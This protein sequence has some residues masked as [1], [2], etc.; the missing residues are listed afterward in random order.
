MSDHLPALQNT[1]DDSATMDHLATPVRPPHAHLWPDTAT[2]D[3][4]GQL[5][6]GGLDLLALAR[7][8]GTPLYVYDEATIRAQCR[9][10]HHELT[11]RWPASAVA[12]AGKAYLSLA[13]CRLLADE[14]ME[15]DVVSAGELGLAMAAGFEPARIHLHGNFKPRSELAQALAAGIGRIVVDSL[16][17]LE[18]V[19]ALARERGERVAIWLRVC[20]DVAT[21]TH[22][23]TQT[24][25][26]SS[27]FGLDVASGT[28][29]E[30]AQ[31]AATSEWLDLA[32]LHAHAGS[33]LIDVTP[34]AQTVR[35]LGEL[36]AELRERFGVAIRELSP[37]GGLGVAYA[38]AERA[39]SI[40]EYAKTV[41]GALAS[42]VERK[43][44]LPPQLIVEPGRAIVARAGVALYTVGPRKVVAGGETFLAVDGGMGDNPRPALY[45]AAYHAA[46][47]ERMTAPAEERVRVVGRYCESGDVLVW[48]VALPR[49]RPGEVLAVA[50]GGA[51]QLAMASTYNLVPRPAV[52]FVA[53]GRARL[54]QRRETL[55]DVLARESG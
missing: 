23:H 9:A 38:P 6:V 55:E 19:E 4:S 50:V 47:P 10:L 17:E 33:H 48:D 13:L 3:A 46:L 40:V 16:E 5:Q 18:A 7:E 51:Y 44:L 14:G 35:L 28:A 54:V 49:A 8:Y 52:V 43:R 30:A 22:A 42:V 53:N 41:A 26:A 32:G 15:L 34:M 37:G 45:G 11:A 39:P 27:K 36:A 1:A 21:Q 20:P 2:L 29:L 31:R 24:G 25:Q 12:Y